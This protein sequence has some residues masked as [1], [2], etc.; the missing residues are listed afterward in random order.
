MAASDRTERTYGNWRK[1]TSPGLG[2]LGMLGTLILMAGLA[3]MVIGMMIWLWSGPI[4]AAVVGVVLAPLLIRDRHGRN[5]L[6]ALTSQISWWRG[7]SKGWHLYRSGPLGITAR[8]S[9]RLPG[10][11]APT[12]LVEAEDS[13]GRPFAM[14]VMPTT[15]HYTIVMECGADGAVLKISC[16]P[17]VRG[18]ELGWGWWLALA[19]G[20]HPG[21]L[22][23][24]GQATGDQAH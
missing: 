22:P 10:L 23:H 12:R 17:G 4:I 24:P 8:G 9:H 20:L 19:P 16:Q 1:P 18:G 3:A 7:K 15:A 6:Q 13:Y 5:G 2:Q 14:I 11:A 21:H